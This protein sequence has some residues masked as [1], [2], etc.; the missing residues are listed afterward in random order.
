MFAAKEKISRAIGDVCNGFVT[1]RHRLLVGNDGTVELGT[2]FADPVS[3]ANSPEAR[4]VG[5]AERQAQ[6]GS[7][8]AFTS[9]RVIVFDNGDQFVD[10]ELQIVVIT[11]K[12]LITAID[13]VV[14]RV[15][16]INKYSD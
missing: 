11:K 6:D 13:F 8:S 12:L 16:G 4:G 1:S 9:N 14:V 10:E 2:G 5:C 3:G 7:L 15:S